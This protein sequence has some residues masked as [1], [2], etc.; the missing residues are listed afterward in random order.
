M[1]IPILASRVQPYQ[2]VI[3]KTSH[4]QLLDEDKGAGFLAIREGRGTVALLD[5][6]KGP[7]RQQNPSGLRILR[8]Q[9]VLLDQGGTRPR[10]KLGECWALAG[11]AWQKGGKR[12]SSRL[13]GVQ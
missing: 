6:G 3:S 13:E 2:N 8:R 12:P 11:N 4:S 9:S 1:R 10:Q 7:E 5:R